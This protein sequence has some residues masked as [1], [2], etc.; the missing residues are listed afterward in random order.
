MAV[1][2]VS[3]LRQM[4]EQVQQEHEVCSSKFTDYTVLIVNTICV[5][6]VTMVIVTIHDYIQYS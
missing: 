4:L 3:Q 2:K 5:Y 1:E 6:I